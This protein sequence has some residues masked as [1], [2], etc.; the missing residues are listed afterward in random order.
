MLK[1]SHYH[2]SYFYVNITFYFSEAFLGCLLSFKILPQKYQLC[3][4]I[5]STHMQNKVFILA[6]FMCLLFWFDMQVIE[7]NNLYHIQRSRSE[8]NNVKN[9]I[10]APVFGSSLLLTSELT[11]NSWFFQ[12]HN[13]STSVSAQVVFILDKGDSS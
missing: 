10:C 3:L 1:F 8:K 7:E 4:I 9:T 13:L 12:F 2:K 11:W 5:S 6:L